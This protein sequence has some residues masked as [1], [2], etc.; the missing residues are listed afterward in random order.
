MLEK[1]VLERYLKEDLEWIKDYVIK[2]HAKGVV[3][4][5]S[6][7]KDSAVVIAMMVNALGKDK[8]LAVS[9]PCNSIDADFEDAKLVADTFGVRMIKVDLSN[10]YNVLEDEIN[11]VIRENLELEL[12]SESKVN[13]KPRMRMLT[14]YSIAQSLGYLVAGTG[15]LCEQ[16]VGYTTKWGDNASDFNPIASFTVDEV[17]EIGRMLNVPEKIINKAPS[18]GLGLKT[19]EEKMGI[20]YSE[21]AE[22]IETGTTENEE[23]K[24]EIIRRFNAAS[25]KRSLVPVF[26]IDRKNYLLDL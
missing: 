14:L 3:V 25:H 12:V 7:G 9:M 1:E 16:M 23:S 19:D 22:M 8:V 21:I 18:D 10:S 20:K 5:N 2:T 26:K 15:N 11:N 24:K 17:L 13:M 4:G 6:G